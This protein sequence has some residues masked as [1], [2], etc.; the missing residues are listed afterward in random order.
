MD[1]P[2]IRFLFPLLVL[3][4]YWLALVRSPYMDSGDAEEAAENLSVKQVQR[5]MA[6]T[7]SLIAEGKYA[8]AIAPLLNLHQ[9]NPDDDIFMYQLAEAYRKIGR[10]REEV[11]MWE[12]YLR[13]SPTPAMACPQ[14][15]QAY[16]MLGQE[17]DAFKAFER[18]L[19]IEENSDNLTLMAT[20]L[21]RRKQ[22]GRAGQL[23][24]KALERSPNYPDP[25]IGLARVELFSG[26]VRQARERV[27]RVLEKLPE[28]ADALLVAGLAAA[29]SGD[30]AAARVYLLKGR[31]IRP[32]DSD[33][34]VALARLGKAR[35]RG[36]RR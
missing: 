11:A 28:D 20:A 17:G 16:R 24:Q 7:R 3:Y 8:A 23:Y 35:P 18:C 1:I 29:R 14:I 22:Y 9:A 30:A 4:V 27:A 21:E 36:K 34:G 32:G 10:Q 6:Q 33:F 25:A 5:L 12:L 31:E 13:H 19:E 2:S 15:G 26:K